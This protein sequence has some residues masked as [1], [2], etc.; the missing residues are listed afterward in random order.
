MELSA[1]I[2]TIFFVI[3][4]IGN[5]PIFLSVLSRVEKKQRQKVLL[6]EMIIGFLILLSFLI[7]GK[8][9]LEALHLS[10]A[11]LQLSGAVVLF[12]IALSLVFPGD[13]SLFKVDGQGTPLIVPLAVPLIAGPSTI[14]V[15]I[16]MA[17]SEP[18]RMHIWVL[19]LT[20]A[21]GASVAILM[22]A[23]PIASLIGK[24][25]IS[26]LEKLVG[27]LLIMVSAQMFI[28]SIGLALKTWGITPA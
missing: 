13:R 2:L 20:I 6:R 21:W 19:A 14:A 27:M 25:G 23:Q 1:A 17:S 26:A 18:A 4:P 10:V 28:D 7:A 11:A 24:R 5:I 16:L 22:G 15:L 12:L 8:Y 3:D 9:I